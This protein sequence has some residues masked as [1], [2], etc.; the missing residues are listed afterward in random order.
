MEERRTDAELLSAIRENVEKVIVGKGEVIDLVLTALLCGGH[1]LIEDV[2]GLGTTTLVSL[3]SA[4]YSTSC[5]SACPRC[6]A[7]T[8]LRRV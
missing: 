1:I 5:S 6:W 4:A 2:P 3:T 7:S 8:A